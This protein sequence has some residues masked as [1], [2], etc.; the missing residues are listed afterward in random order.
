MLA[1]MAR[2]ASLVKGPAAAAKV[3]VPLAFSAEQNRPS[4]LTLP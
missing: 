4:S 2:L 3:S 1:Q